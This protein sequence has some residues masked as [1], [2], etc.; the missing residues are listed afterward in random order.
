MSE[1]R[2]AAY[3]RNVPWGVQD[4][5]D[6]FRLLFQHHPEP[7]W[8]YDLDTLRFLDVNNAAVEQYGYSREEFA[9]MTI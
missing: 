1:T 8:I 2:V 6:V 4:Q 5:P 9:Q 3:S 7:M